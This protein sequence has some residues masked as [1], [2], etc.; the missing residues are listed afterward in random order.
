[1]PVDEAMVD[2]FKG[3]L[4]GCALG[5]AVGELAFRH[6]DEMS[7]RR[8][9]DAAWQLTYT[10]DTAMTIALAEALVE[11]VT[12]DPQR[13]GDRFAAHYRREPWRG[14]GP[15]PPWIFDEVK[16][17]GIPY[18][19]AAGKLYG[20]AGSYGNGA[21]MRAA[22]VALAFHGRPDL[23]SQACAA[24][25]PTHTHPIGQDGAAVQA[26][27]VALALEAE[28]PLPVA[29]FAERLTATARTPEMSKKMAAVEALLASGAEA[30]EA[31]HR[32]G[33]SIAVHESMPFAVHAFLRHA[34]SFED[35]ILCAALNGGD[36]DTLGA[37]AGAISGAYLGMAA[38]P[39]Q[40][41]DKLEN[42]DMIET[43]AVSLSRIKD[44]RSSSPT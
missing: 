42:R 17:R 18:G 1:M 27:A 24:A 44:D 38:L 39:V 40:W 41:L 15:G 16:Y 33:R 7:L 32:I 5:D 31:A 36:R 9:V 11:D 19:E 34:Q 20:G 28:T 13:L 10:D 8:A 43:L 26:T 25:V 6:P 35:C 30:Y 29:Q 21:A 22:P 3:A 12:I 37:M 4:L 23:Y 2:R 14:Y